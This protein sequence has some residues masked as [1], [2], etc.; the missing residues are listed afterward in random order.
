MR[1]AL[2][3]DSAG[4]LRWFEEDPR[5]REIVAEADRAGVGVMRIRAVAGGALTDRAVVPPDA[6]LIR[7]H[8]R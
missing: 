8:H 5:P 1:P 2:A 4:E 3:L 7:S 6:Q